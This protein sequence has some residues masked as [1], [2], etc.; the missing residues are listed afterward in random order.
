MKY[1]CKEINILNVQDKFSVSLKDIVD[2][3]LNLV[4]VFFNAWN[5][6]C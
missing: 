6:F 1:V 5:R 2:F 3:F 4:D